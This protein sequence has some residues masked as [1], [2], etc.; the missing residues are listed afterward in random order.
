MNII[1][2]NN[3]KYLVFKF[4]IYLWIIKAIIMCDSF[5]MNEYSFMR[6]GWAHYKKRTLPG[7]AG[8]GSFGCDGISG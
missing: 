2:L 1:M 8:K 7:L 5:H 4:L 6:F 3:N